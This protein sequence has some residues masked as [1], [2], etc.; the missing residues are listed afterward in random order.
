[1]DQ[2]ADLCF[3]HQVVLAYSVLIVQRYDA[4]FAVDEILN[5]SAVRADLRAEPPRIR[6]TIMKRRRLLLW[7]LGAKR[8]G[9]LT[10][11]ARSTCAPSRPH[12][13]REGE[14]QGLLSSGLERSDKKKDDAATNGGV[15]SY[16]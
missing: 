7:R 8:Q 9:D 3:S 16:L 12:Q 2:G 11:A 13:E 6:R 1:M 14:S 4:G 15:C 10:L 5:I